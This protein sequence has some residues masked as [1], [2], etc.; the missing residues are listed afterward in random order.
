MVEEYIASYVHVGA[1][2]WEVTADWG[3]TQIP[4]WFDRK[5]QTGF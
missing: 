4:E 2:G 3:R 5:T 1:L